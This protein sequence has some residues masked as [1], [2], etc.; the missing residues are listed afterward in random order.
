MSFS[1]QMPFSS[2][3]FGGDA[4]LY[5]SLFAGM[6]HGFFVAVGAGNGSSGPSHWLQVAAGWRGMLIE[7][8][9]GEQRI[10]LMRRWAGVPHC[11]RSFN[12]STGRGA[13]PRLPELP[14]PP[15][16]RINSQPLCGLHSMPALQVLTDSSPTAAL[17]RYACTQ[18][19]AVAGLVR[20]TGPAAPSSN[21]RADLAAAA[22]AFG[23]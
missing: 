20:C 1:P 10:L 12:M 8:D 23:S 5:R 9:E 17:M 19:S 3:G 16:L 18:Q 22:A 21:S 4:W 14:C 6:R 15:P 11:V 13:L 7:G 2:Q